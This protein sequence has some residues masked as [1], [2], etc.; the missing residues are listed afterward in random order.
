MLLTIDIGTSSFKSALWKIDESKSCILAYASFPLKIDI[1]NNIKH[2]TSPLLWIKSFEDCCKK[3]LLDANIEN[4][5]LVKAVIIS[6]NGPS[7]VPVLNEPSFCGGRLKVPAENA[8]LWLDRRAVKYQDEV[9]SVM[10]GFVDAS[11]FLPKILYIKNDESDIYKKTKY[12]IGCPEYLAYALTGQAK[13]VI[14][15]EGFDRWF[16]NNEKLEKLHLE[17]EKFPDFI[18]PSDQFG[19]I[20]PDIAQ[21]FGFNKNTPVISGGPDFFAAILGSG[22]VKPGQ[23]CDRAG[24]SEGINLCVKNNVNDKRLMSYAHPVKPYWNLSG[25]INTTGK[26]IEWGCNLFDI[27]FNDFIKLSENTQSGSSGIVFNPYLAGERTPL[28]EPNARANWNGIN[29]TSKKSD[30]AKSILESI[31]FAIRDVIGVMEETGE[32]TEQLHVTGKLA[33]CAALNQIKADITGKIVLEG[34]YKE[35][36]L[37]GLAVIGRCSLGD[38]SSYEE[39]SSNMVKFEKQYE[40]N[41]KNAELYNQLFNNYKNYRR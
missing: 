18:K 9:S 4:L 37:L 31:G 6:G 25:I 36:E 28:W 27:S 11:F 12:F 35:S 5:K 40:P 34:M 17:K 2:E 21:H 3:L 1:S 15:C 23:A 29:L 32:K 19:I 38:Y 33:G 20:L 14:P 30:F 39:A 8:R 22:V 24:S 41:P 16:W 7:L 26:A 13:T 10:G